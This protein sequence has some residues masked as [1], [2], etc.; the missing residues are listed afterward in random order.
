MSNAQHGAGAG[1]GAAAHHPAAARMAAGCGAAAPAPS[2]RVANRPMGGQLIVAFFALTDVSEPANE[3]D[4]SDMS[5]GFSVL[6]NDSVTLCAIYQDP[7]RYLYDMMERSVVVTFGTRFSFEEAEIAAIEG[8]VFNNPADF[9]SRIHAIFTFDGEECDPNEPFD[10]DVDEDRYAL[11]P[12]MRDVIAVDALYG[13]RTCKWG[14]IDSGLKKPKSNKMS[15][16]NSE[17]SSVDSSSSDGEP[18]YTHYSSNDDDD[19]DDN[20]NEGEV[21]KKKKKKRAVGQ[22]DG[23]NTS[24]KRSKHAPDD[25]VN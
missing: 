3:L 11:T 1:A 12:T 21:D 23:A 22:D 8:G 13:Y 14:P 25:E 10:Y 15:G 2:L 24:A 6:C 16:A 5:F 20:D 18:I 4:R 19:K 17:A 7:D 9:P